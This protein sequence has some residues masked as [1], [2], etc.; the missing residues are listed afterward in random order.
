MV[1]ACRA[2]SV[3]VMVLAC[4]AESVMVMVLACRA[5][6]VSLRWGKSCRRR[7]RWRALQAASSHV[8]SD[9]RLL[10]PP[11]QRIRSQDQDRE[12]RLRIRIEDHML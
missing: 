10:A 1:L 11:L 3:M 6:S 2:V 4:R 9:V 5:V 8:V 7:G 12:R